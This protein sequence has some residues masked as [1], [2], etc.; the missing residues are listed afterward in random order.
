SSL[1]TFYGY[2]WLATDGL[3]IAGDQLFGIGTLGG[4]WADGTAWSTVIG[5][6]A[7]SATISLLSTPSP[8]PIPIPAPGAL[9]LGAIGT[10]S[11]IWLRRRRVL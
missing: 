8:S 3:S 6:N 4:F 9:L 11:V 5:W 7:E 10:S 2:G 1:T